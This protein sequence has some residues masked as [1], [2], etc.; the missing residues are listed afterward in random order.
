LDP[1]TAHLVA[2]RLAS[3]NLSPIDRTTNDKILESTVWGKTFP[4]PIG[5]AAGFDKHAEAIDG[6]L[7][8]GFSFVEV[9]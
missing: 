3:L 1:E 8:M 6:L 2:I 5:L 4:T 9:F 7:R